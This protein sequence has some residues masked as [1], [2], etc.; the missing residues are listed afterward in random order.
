M[1]P[2]ETK[3]FENECITFCE[4]NTYICKRMHNLHM[5]TDRAVDE[6]WGHAITA[7]LPNY[8]V[9]RAVRRG[10]LRFVLRFCEVHAHGVNTVFTRSSVMLGL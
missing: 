2:Q 3:W 1:R 8:L 7:R 9:R 10:V 5:F 4:T 6:I